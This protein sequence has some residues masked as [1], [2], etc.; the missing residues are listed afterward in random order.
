MAVLSTVKLGAVA[1]CANFIG[2]SAYDTSV[3][4]KL[5]LSHGMK[6]EVNF[7][8]CPI[9]SSEEDDAN[10]TK[11]KRKKKQHKKERQKIECKGGC[12]QQTSG[13][14]GYC[15][16]C[17]E[18]GVCKKTAKKPMNSWRPK[19]SYHENLK[20]D[21]PRL[22]LKDLSTVHGCGTSLK[23]RIKCFMDVVFSGEAIERYEN[24]GNK[25]E[26]DNIQK[27]PMWQTWDEVLGPF[28]SWMVEME[29][30]RGHRY[31][32]HQISCFQEIEKIF[33]DVLQKL[34]LRL[35]KVLLQCG[36]NSRGYV[37]RHI[38]RLMKPVRD[39]LKYCRSAKLKNM[40]LV[41]VRSSMP[42][43]NPVILDLEKRLEN[44]KE[45]NRASGWS[46]GSY[47]ASQ[48]ELNAKKDLKKR[49]DFLGANDDF[50]QVYQ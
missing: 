11:E 18:R 8:R 45:K 39:L 24:W 7:N 38:S 31:L 22:V 20:K 25:D 17:R 9:N 33:G 41:N 30:R 5:T 26:S 48:E 29:K 36:K 37:H 35:E 50:F 42:E 21:Y 44:A 12:S 13:L 15:R 43:H 47:I 4:S 1:V 27:L 32:D 2:A 10:A 6:K 16:E 3:Q 19:V 23:G 49:L 34:K 28:M 46:T 40:A 14:L